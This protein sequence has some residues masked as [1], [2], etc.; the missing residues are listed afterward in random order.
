[1]TTTEF[2][3]TGYMKNSIF[4][5]NSFGD[6]EVQDFAN[7]GAKAGFTYKIDG[8]NY[9]YTNG[10]AMNRAP[11]ARVAYASP[12]NRDQI[13]PGL[14]DEKVY[15]FEIGYQHR[16]PGL[17]ARA[18]YF[19]TQINDGLKLNRFFLPGEITNFGT[20]ILNG[21]DERHAGFELALQVKLS[22]TLSANAA[23]SISENIYTS[24][25][26]GFFIID[27]DGQ[28]RDRGTIYVKNFYV[29]GTPQTAA[30]FGLDYRSPKF[31][32]LSATVNY[33]NH[34]Y[35]DFSPERRTEDAVFGL[36]KD[37]PFYNEIVNQEKVPDA[38]T[39]DLFA[40]KSW[41]LN[42]DLFFSFTAGVTNL[43]NETVIQGGYEQLRFERADVQRTGINV[44]PPRYFYAY[45]TNFFVLGALRF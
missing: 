19:H 16:S 18:T 43:L 33:F 9:L 20:Y 25:P 23:A 22:P 15:S 28:I 1:M 7:F 35:I 10:L 13:V 3:R 37:S 36:E 11:D 32:S 24:R 17:K 38:F 4:P 30:S 14:T 42:S 40:Y 45:G 21:L 34:N 6:S 39:V 41:R 26:H 31:W 12:R 27:D 29:P 2:W 5:D 8:R 44:F